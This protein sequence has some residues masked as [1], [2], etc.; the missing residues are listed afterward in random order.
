MYSGSC[1]RIIHVGCFLIRLY[2]NGIIE[3][4]APGGADTDK[5]AKRLMNDATSC[6]DKC[7]EDR[8]VSTNLKNLDLYL[9]CI[10]SGVRS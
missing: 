1:N 7:V 2:T 5:R 3:T 10:T 6:A 4:I 8:K 9:T